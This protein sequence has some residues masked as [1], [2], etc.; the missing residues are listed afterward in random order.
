MGVIDPQA[1]VV[2]T[3]Y[4]YSGGAVELFLNPIEK[5]LLLLALMS[6]Q[7]SLLVCHVWK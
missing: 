6:P 2:R 5:D 1:D 7:S 3:G 4:D